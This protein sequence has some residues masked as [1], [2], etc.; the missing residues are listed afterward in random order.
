MPRTGI[1]P[2]KESNRRKGGRRSL[3][4]APGTPLAHRVGIGCVAML[5][6][7]G[8]AACADGEAGAG[9]MRVSG[10]TTV[11]PVAT[12]ASEVLREQGYDITVATDGGSAGAI[13]QLGANQIDIAMSSK[14]FSDEDQAAHPDTDFHPTQ[15]G[16]DAVG[17][18]IR[19]EVADAGVTNLT[20]EQVQGI[21]E[22]T[23]TNWSEVGGPDLG[24]F[25]YDK[26]PGR[27]TREVLDKYLYGEGEAPPPPDTD[28]FAI[29]GGNL[30][31]RSK[32]KSTAGAVAPLSTGFIDGHDDLVAV[33]LDGVSP[34][35]EN[36]ASGDYPMTRPLYLITDG[37]PEGPL[38]DFIDYVLSD[39]GQAILPTHGYLGIHELGG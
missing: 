22:G 33:H 25:V 31:T 35:I 11:A 5:L 12:D 3:D 13:S 36:V 7:A 1:F 26:E 27:G 29:V 24:V 14:P 38:K 19:S 2:A 15:I 39:E 6:A 37:P 8:L 10:S 28:N 23:I 18:I 9:T 4:R 20:R 32:V 21:F 17:V 34:D 16:A 30:E